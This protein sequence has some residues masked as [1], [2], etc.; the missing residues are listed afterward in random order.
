MIGSDL[1]SFE[2]TANGNCGDKISAFTTADQIE[3]LANKAL[4]MLSALNTG[5][6]KELELTIR[7]LNAIA[8][9]GLY[10]AYK[11]RL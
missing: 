8:F 11:Y 5:S 6:S 2:N 10:N 9:L 3:E 7:N 1:C 4:A